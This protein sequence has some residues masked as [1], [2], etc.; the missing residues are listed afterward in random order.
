M[1]NLI[2]IISEL[3][4]PKDMKNSFGGFKYRNAEGILESVKP[5]LEK[6]NCL[7]T[8]TSDVFQVG[9]RYYIKAIA[10]I[11]DGEHTYSATACA[12]EQEEKKGMDAAQVT[13]ATLSYAK[14][15]ALCNLFDIDDSAEDADTDLSYI[16]QNSEDPN[17]KEYLKKNPTVAQ[18]LNVSPKP[19]PSP[20][21]TAGAKS[22]AQVIGLMRFCNT[23]EEVKKVADDNKVDWNLPEYA[24]FAKELASKFTK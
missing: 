10:T 24:A 6:Y 12:R 13:G 5:L 8:V 4:A 16:R 2:K 20:K 17:V 11:T 23:R 7:L 18:K 3:R 1:E 21:G 15:Y 9:D 19:A 22:V 14:K